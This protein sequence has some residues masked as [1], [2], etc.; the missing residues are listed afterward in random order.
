M[1][2]EDLPDVTESFEYDTD[3][4][5]F[6]A[7]FDTEMRPSMAVVTLVAA[8]SETPATDLEPLHSQID[9]D[10]LDA[11]MDRESPRPEDS[12]CTVRFEFHDHDVSVTGTGTVTATP[13][14]DT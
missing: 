1:A 10:A 9:P 13:I 11:L 2:S 14:E 5:A 7:T 6:R 4:Q 8:V 12:E 3:S